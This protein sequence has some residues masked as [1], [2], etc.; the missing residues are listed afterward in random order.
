MPTQDLPIAIIG[1]GPVGLAAASHLVARGESPLVFEAGPTVGTNMRSW[2]HVRLFSPWQYVVDPVAQSLL[3]ADGWPM[4]DD[5][6]LPLGRDVVER[7]LQPLAELPQLAPHIHLDTRVTAVS[8][9]GLDKMT[10]PG[11]DDVPFLLALREE[12]GSE[13]H[14]MARAVIDAS[15]TYHRSNPLGASG[16][17]ARYERA[18]A[19]RIVYGIPDVLGAERTRYAG[20][21]TLVVGGGHSAFHAALD[22]H[23][24][25]Q[26][27]PQTEVVWA[28]RRSALDGVF[29]GED[30]D[31]LS[32]RGRLGTRARRLVQSGHVDVVTGFHV[33]ALDRAG[34]G[35][36]VIGADDRR[37]ENIDEMIAVTGLR[38]DL[39]MLRELR[40][41]LDE[42]VESP[43]RLAPLI[44][45]NVHSCGTA[46][47]HGASELAHAERDF[48]I[49]GM[50]SY[51]RAP[52]FLLMT[53]Y[54][55]VRSVVAALTRDEA[56][57]Q[58]VELTLPATGVCSGAAADSC[59]NEECAA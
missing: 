40:L 25:Q 17:P 28:I 44:D 50:K 53:G 37:I 41:S 45:P 20:R 16:M 47:P 23:A 46:P 42:G 30:Q 43:A 55:Q 39:E 8:R 4:P 34:D 14:V 27:E 35:I 48:Y 19:D 29:G 24:L 54:E 11:R 13:S 38:P 33:A 5:D 10:T 51:G 59:C 21:R 2:S 31:D 12:N 9:A 32:E 49:V 18:L 57:A 58:S 56:G 26:E 15:G 52:T 7:Y 3:E 36:T 22:L 1:G 6:A